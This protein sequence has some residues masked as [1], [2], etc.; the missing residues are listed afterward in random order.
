MLGSCA[1]DAKDANNSD[2]ATTNAP[3]S[4]SMVID[5]SKIKTKEEAGKP[6]GGDLQ[7]GK[8]RQIPTSNTDGL[9]MS[10]VFRGANKEILLVRQ[11]PLQR[12]VGLTFQKDSKEIFLTQSSSGPYDKNAIFK[13]PNM[14]WQAKGNGGVLIVNGK[15]TNF[16]GL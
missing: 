7:P 14:T 15:A 8:T 10:D 12:Q 4:D 13:G 2:N 6:G 5:A 16:S 9:P 11:M 3:K 1:N